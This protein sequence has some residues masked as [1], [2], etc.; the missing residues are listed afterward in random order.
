MRRE[1]YECD[2][3]YGTANEFGFDFLR[4]RLLLRRIREG[5]TDVVAQMLGHGKAAEAEKPV[6]REPYFALVDEADNILIDE[7]RTPLIIS[8]L[9]DEAAKAEAELFRWSA[10]AVPQFVEDEHYEFDYE[11]RTAEL[12]GE[13]RR[14][15]RSLPRSGWVEQ[16]GMLA[17]YD[18]IERAIRANQGFILDRHYVVR[19]GEIVIVDEFTGRLV[20]RPQV[21]RRPASG[22]RSQGRR[23]GDHRHRPRRPRNDP[24]LFPP[25]SAPGGHDGH[26]R[27]ERPRTAEDLQSA[28]GADSDASP[29][30]SH[31][32][33]PPQFT[34][35]RTTNS[36]PS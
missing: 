26:G 8:S 24:G 27:H 33:C 11:K 34:A 9:P 31:S 1:A 21:A 6:Q 18:S 29:A 17:L 12:T 15:V 20:R 35:P 23:D 14:L 30:D 32:S 25:L 5:Q 4:D 2:I 28:S 10:A 16:V 19:K 36:P 3:T 13:G 22:H 7:A